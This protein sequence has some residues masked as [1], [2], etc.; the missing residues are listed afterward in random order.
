MQDAARV[1]RGEPV[2][3]LD[4]GLERLANGQAAAQ[5]P[6]LQRLALDELEDD[7]RD[8]ALVPDVVHGHDRRVL[9]R[10]GRPRLVL[11]QAQPLGV[12]RRLEVEELDRDLAAEARVAGAIHLGHPADAEG[13]R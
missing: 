8:V 4:R 13:G 2:A 7:V 11:E 5:Q 1:G 10:A 3:D 12:A 9:D 6:T